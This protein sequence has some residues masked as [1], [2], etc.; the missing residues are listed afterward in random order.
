MSLCLLATV[1]QAHPQG[2][3]KR[4][5]FTLTKTGGEGLVVMDVDSGD[6]CALIRAGADANKDGRLSPEETGALKQKLVAMATRA[7][8][9]SF[10]SAPIAAV[11][12]ESKLSLREDLG[13]STSG[14]SVAVLLDLSHPQEVTPGMRFEVED[15]SPD[16]STIRLQVFQASDGQEPAEPA[17]D[18][19][20]ESGKVARVRLG[21]LAQKAAS[22]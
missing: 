2:F 11:V 5:V 7:L 10:S 21:S 14:L 18:A 19:A 17:F 9:L 16:L 22:H 12:K 4:L 20:L 1:A 8:K 13:V 15:T 6:R 3:H